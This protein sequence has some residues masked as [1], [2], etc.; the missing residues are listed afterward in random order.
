MAMEQR[1]RLLA[2]G[3]RIVAE[4]W[5]FP[6]RL[7]GE[8]ELCRRIRDDLQSSV[9]VLGPS[10]DPQTAERGTRVRVLEPGAPG[11]LASCL[12]RTAQELGLHLTELPLSG[13]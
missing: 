9:V 3:G 1:F 7:T 6:V 12:A 13:G 4:A 5:G 2:S 8:P 10:L 11:W